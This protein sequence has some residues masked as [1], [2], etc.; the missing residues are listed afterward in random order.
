MMPLR[1]PSLRPIALFIGAMFMFPAHQAA[2]QQQQEPE[3]GL[4]LYGGIGWGY[5]DNLLRVPDNRP[6]FQGKRSDRWR[7]A[8]A[9]VMLPFGGP[10]G[11][12][13]AILIDVFCGV[14]SGASF[15]SH[16]QNLYT[17]FE[18]PQDNGHFFLALDPGLFLPREEF[19]AK[20][21]LFVQL[22]KATP[23]AAGNSEILM[24]GEPEANRMQARLAEGIP[25]T[26]ADLAMLREQ[27]D[28]VGLTID[29]ATLG[30]G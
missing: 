4:K 15:G 27:A 10:K 24:P 18:K 23:P 9:G 14:L 12:A 7:Q 21:D 16:V 13:I 28:L 3:E 17:E 6:A 29:L 30:K 22:L 11:S 26:A 1:H 5:D 20:V 25:L 19:Y 8:E 2:A